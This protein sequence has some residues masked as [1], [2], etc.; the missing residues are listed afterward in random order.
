MEL[1]DHVS[2]AIEGKMQSQPGI[3]FE[4]AFEEET[5]KFNKKDFPVQNYEAGLQ[6][7]P[8]KEW[9]YFTGR[10]I[11]RL[12][13][14]FLVLVSPVAFLNYKLLVYVELLY[15]LAGTSWYL[16]FLFGFKRKYKESRKQLGLYFSEGL[17]NYLFPI[18]YFVYLILKP[19]PKG[20]VLTQTKSEWLFVISVLGGLFIIA[21]LLAKIDAK[22]RQYRAA[23][24]HTRFFLKINKMLTAEQ[25][26]RIDNF[27]KDQEIYFYDLRKEVVDHIS[28][29]IEAKMARQ[30][31]INFDYELSSAAL[32]LNIDGFR[33]TVEEK[34]LIIER[35]IKRRQRKLFLDYLK[36]PHLIV[37]LTL[38]AIL[39]LPFFYMGLSAKDHIGLNSAVLGVVL[40]WILV[41]RKK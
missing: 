29:S 40:V 6:Y 24:K 34:E 38:I 41:E 33:K 12:L 32:T 10:R 4:Q 2:E 15:V 31:Y 8:I 25:I 18:L 30:P 36:W 3:C 16:H 39:M 5:G 35:E 13:A 17:F 21:A 1:V 19:L 37:T 7:N 20:T 11:A 26:K 14:I 27:C 23:K 22:K 9:N 28:T